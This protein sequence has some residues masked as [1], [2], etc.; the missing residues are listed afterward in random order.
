MDKW[1][2]NVFNRGHTGFKLGKTLENLCSSHCLLSSTLL[3]TFK[4]LPWH[5]SFEA[6]CDSDML[7]FQFCHFVGTPKLKTEQQIHSFIHSF[8]WHVQN[9]TIPCCSQELL[10]F[11]SVIYF[12][13]PPFSTNYSSIL[14][15]LWNNICLYLMRHNSPVTYATTLFHV[16]NDSA[17]SAPW[18]STQCQPTNYMIAPHIL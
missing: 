17:D 6:N 9:A 16:R 5:F 18:T 3:P 13:L 1:A 11:P 14:P 7:F 8:H 12:F 4:K 15:H 2:F 10:P